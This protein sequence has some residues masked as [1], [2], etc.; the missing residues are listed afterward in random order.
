MANYEKAKGSGKQSLASR[1]RELRKR[2]ANPPPRKRIAW[3]GQACRR[4]DPWLNVLQ[5]KGKLT[6]LQQWKAL[7]SDSGHAS[8][9]QGSNMEELVWASCR[10]HRII[11]RWQE[12]IQ[13]TW[14]IF[15]H[16]SICP[17]KWGQLLSI[18]SWHRRRYFGEWK[19][20]LQGDDCSNRKHRTV[21]F[22]A[23]VTF[24]IFSGY[25]HTVWF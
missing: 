20:G 21:P 1:C 15:Y 4:K 8:L 11:G 25:Q 16:E 6:S 12:W 13:N 9:Y 5:R 7:H 3:F 17:K 24:D 22:A 14:Q 18:H 19:H 2:R 10:W 23:T